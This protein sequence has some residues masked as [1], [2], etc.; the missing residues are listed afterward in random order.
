M[1][2]TIL[3]TVMQIAEQ[4]WLKINLILDLEN[5][6]LFQVI[7]PY[8]IR[9]F[10]NPLI[11]ALSF[12]ALLGIPYGLYKL[13]KVSAQKEEKLDQIIEEMEADEAD[14]GNDNE[15]ALPLFPNEKT[16]PSPD[17]PDLSVLEKLEEKNR[18]SESEKEFETAH[19]VSSEDDSEKILDKSASEQEFEG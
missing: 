9:T 6:E 4:I 16:P 17:E 15:E 13:R 11:S 14:L 3:E 18:A 19:A 8:L 5:S 7:K 10:E 12:V 1:V 2:A